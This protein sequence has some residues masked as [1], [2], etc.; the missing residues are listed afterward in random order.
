MKENKNIFILAGP[1]V[2]TILFLIGPPES[3]NKESFGLLLTVIWMAIWWITEAIPIGVTSLLPIILFPILGIMDLSITA[4][5]YGNKI[6][7]LFIGG[8][9][10]ALAVEK[11]NLHKKSKDY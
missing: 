2:F 8:F 3:L 4:E 6:I 1:I 10:L 9:I 11:W 5:S 7:F